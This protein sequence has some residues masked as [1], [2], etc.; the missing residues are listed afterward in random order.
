MKKEHAQIQV[1]FARQKRNIAWFL[2][3]IIT[4]LTSI[5]AWKWL[6]EPKT[7]TAEAAITISGEQTPSD[8]WTNTG[9][10]SATTKATQIIGSETFVREVFENNPAPA[11]TFTYINHGII[12]KAKTFPFVVEVLKTPDTGSI[13]LN[14]ADAGDN[15]YL[16]KTTEKDATSKL[17]VYNDSVSINDYSFRIVR[18]EGFVETHAIIGTEAVYQAELLSSQ[19]A[20]ESLLNNGGALQVSQIND[21]VKINVSSYGD[22]YASEIANTLAQSYLIK[23]NNNNQIENNITEVQSVKTNTPENLNI[24]PLPVQTGEEAVALADKMAKLQL[25]KEALDN[26]SRN[27]RERIETNYSDVSTEGIENESILRGLRRL[28]EMY[29]KLDEEP[30][31]QE[32]KETIS[33]RKK[34]IGNE[35]IEAR[36]EVAQDLET[37]KEDLSSLGEPQASV[38]EV[39]VAPLSEKSDASTP[40]NKTDAILVP[41][42]PMTAEANTSFWAYLTVL[43]G[44][45]M[46]FMTNRITVFR[47]RYKLALTLVTNDKKTLLPTTYGVS[48]IKKSAISITAPV[49]NLCAEILSLP[50]T[51]VIAFTSLHRKEGKTFV[52][53]R[54]AMALAALD[55]KVLVVDMSFHNQNMEAIFG[56]TC[57]LTIADV[58]S[59]SCDMLQAIQSTPIPGLDLIVGG[60]FKHGVRSLLSWTERET[61]FDQL[62]NFYDYII[63]D[64]DEVSCG[65]EA[66]V[67]LKGSD[68]NLFMDI[69]CGKNSTKSQKLANFAEEKSLLNTFVVFNETSVRSTPNILETS[70]TT[71]K[72][73]IA[74]SRPQPVMETEHS[75]N[76]KSESSNKPSFLKRV[77][78][79][80]F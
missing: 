63:V 60:S 9:I 14:I 43:G 54:I 46:L 76:E 35:L 26:L 30:G 12:T 27:I 66:M 71:K 59:G 34:R 77:A 37:A 31:N 6:S 56:T 72:E 61:A 7:F 67:F 15:N 64:T 50:K 17:A 25:Q 36:K 48:A 70:K 1:L 32:L 74:D 62:R 52:A 8:F 4:L 19:A 57:E 39:T 10:V 20:T 13:K 5:A 69:D 29:A 53:S 2:F 49:D 80:F 79:W 18:N 42:T 16:I 55:K 47:N 22:G 68:L 24:T 51:K 58:S 23:L 38:S 28:G 73:N 44:L 41:A 75:A 11:K 33:E 40:S 65:P 3:S 21:V 78:L 45:I